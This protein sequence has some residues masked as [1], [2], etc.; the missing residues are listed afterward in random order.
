MGWDGTD[1]NHENRD[2]PTNRT[3]DTTTTTTTTQFYSNSQHSR[4][5]SERQHAACKIKN[6][7]SWPK[8]LPN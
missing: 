2:S 8:M 1:G 7:S 4:P 5:L 3:R 6:G